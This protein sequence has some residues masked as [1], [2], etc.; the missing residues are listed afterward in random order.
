[1]QISRPIVIW[2][3]FLTISLIS[4]YG[5]RKPRKGMD[6]VL[7]YSQ[8]DV[9]TCVYAFPEKQI[10]IV[11]ALDGAK[12]EGILYGKSLIGTKWTLSF[13]TIPCTFGKAGLAAKDMKVEGDMKTPSGIY[14]LGPVFGY[15]QDV[16][17]FLKFIEL[18][19][20]HFWID[21]AHSPD[22]N[23]L[24]SYSLKGFSAEKMKRADH[25]YEYGIV[26]QYNSNPVVKGKGSAIFI[27]VQ[28]DDRAPTAGCIAISKVGIKNLI[29]WFQTDSAF[30]LIGMEKDSIY[31]N[32][33]KE[34]K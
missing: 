20:N 19:N 22:Y 5:C 4:I 34:N 31:S 11:R 32:G 2:L 16:F 8:S 6:L 15:K 27:H 33:L 14:Q 17:S 21:D 12:A 7:A 26:I 24:V 10:I 9:D 29:E 25:L 23:R 3:V 28:R 30:I 13:D 1:M 18:T